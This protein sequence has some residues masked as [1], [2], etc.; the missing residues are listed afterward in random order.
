MSGYINVPFFLLEEMEPLEFD[1]DTVNSVQD[2][3]GTSTK[4]LLET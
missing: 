1:C 2:T 4:C 3:F